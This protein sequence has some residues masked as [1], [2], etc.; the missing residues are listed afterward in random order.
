MSQMTAAVGDPRDANNNDDNGMGGGDATDEAYPGYTSSALADRVKDFLTGFKDPDGDRKY[1]RMID[2]MMPRETKHVVVDYNDLVEEQEM[3]AMFVT[4]P[5][6]ILDAFSRAIRE[7][8]EVRFYDYAEMIGDEIRARIINYPME[9]SL[10]KIN[11]STIGTMTSVSGMVVRASEVSPLARELVYMCPDNHETRIVNIKGMDVKGPA[12]CD[13][14]ECKMRS[15]ELDPDASRFI[16]FQILRLQELPEDLPPGQLPD[17]L[18]ITVKQDLVDYARPGDRIALTGIVRVEQESVAGISKSRSGL[19]RLRLEGNNIEFLGGR[20]KSRKLDREEISPDDERA[21]RALAQDPDV[22]DRLV[23]SFA[24]HIKGQNLVKESILLLLVGSK[25][26]EREDGT[27]IRGDI[28][29]FLVGDP[30]IAKSELLKFCS[31][32]APRGLY[33]S[34]RGTTAAGLTAAVVR[35]KTG[36]MMLEAGAVVLGDQGMV[37]IDE[38]DKMNPED[39]SALHEV[40]EQQS[41]S[42]AKGGIVATLNAR[43]SILAAA[44]PLYG[45]YDQYKNITENINIPIPLL[46]RF[47]LIFVMRDSQSEEFDVEIARHV[48][49]MHAMQGLD[50]RNLIDADMLTKY[51]SYAKRTRTTMTKEAED[52]IIG[53]YIKMRKIAK[54][55]DMTPVTP[56]QLGGIIRLANARARL[57]MKNMVEKEDAERAIH[58]LNA[59]LQDAGIDVN[60]GS[61]DIGVLQGKPRSEVSKMQLFMDVLRSLQGEN[62][63]PVEKSVL[64]KELE[65]TEKFTADDAHNYIRKLHSGGVIYEPKTG[66]YGKV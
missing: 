10:R 20:S 65:T 47:D 53:H 21:I 31:R 30:G 12:V 45:K 43:T 13:N 51:L 5:D 25:Q 14:P 33:T 57:L 64:V 16:D 18:D 63:N 66:Y 9:R 48:M 44:N 26:L 4:S 36:I 17:Y 49:K 6:L 54:S 3:A 61:V 27:K 22:Y 46:S 28:N 19:Y 8:L 11:A 38:F 39:R 55:E 58:L 40:M 23:A 24:P 52:I 41:A 2:E 34:G 1:L 15:F 7:V 37:A 60:T 32:I 50:T 35:D 59:M 42:I 29:I 56:R 62:L